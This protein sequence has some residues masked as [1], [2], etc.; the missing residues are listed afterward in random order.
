[1]FR[2]LSTKR[3]ASTCEHS[4]SAVA[5]CVDILPCDLGGSLAHVSLDPL[6]AARYQDDS[7]Y[8]YVHADCPR[9]GLIGSDRGLGACR[10]CASST[11]TGATELAHTR[12]CDRCSLRPGSSLSRLKVVVIIRVLLRERFTRR[13]GGA[14]KPAPFA[15]RLVP[16]TD[17]SI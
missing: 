5:N 3:Q 7:R 14:E 16:C 13:R 4:Q 12:M 6:F 2:V 11:A 8:R 10:C 9:S 1:M 17:V 15:G